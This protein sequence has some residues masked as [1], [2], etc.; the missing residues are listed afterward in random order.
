MTRCF[1][2]KPGDKKP[3]GKDAKRSHKAKD[4]MPGVRSISLVGTNPEPDVDALYGEALRRTELCG[5]PA[6]RLRRLLA[7]PYAICRSLIKIEPRVTTTLGFALAIPVRSLQDLTET[8][9]ANGFGRH[10]ENTLHGQRGWALLLATDSGNFNR[11]VGRRLANL[12]LGEIRDAGGERVYVAVR[13]ADRWLSDRLVNT[14]QFQ[15]DGLTV[16]HHSRLIL[17]HQ[18]K[19]LSF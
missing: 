13:Q 12:M 3:S 2:P 19:T 16:E 18:L 11:G 6:A 9:A 5:D 1:E 10:V 17:S 8:F 7:D 14:L 4:T 15:R